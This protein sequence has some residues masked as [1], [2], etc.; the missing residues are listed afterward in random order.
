MAT[1]HLA[2]DLDDEASVKTGVD[3]WLALTN[4]SGEGMV[5]KPLDP[6]L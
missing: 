1:N 2:V 5:V 6:R 3:W 4:S